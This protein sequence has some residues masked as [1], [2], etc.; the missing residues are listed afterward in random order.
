MTE[1]AVEV[2]LPKIGLTMQEGTIDE[3]LVPTGGVVAE[4][5]PLVRLA[6][7]KVDVDV[8]AEAGGLFHPVVPAGATVPAGALIGWLLAEGEELPGA[9]STG[10][11]TAPAD[12]VS[13]DSVPAGPN[14]VPAGGGVPSAA[15][16]LNGT[17][18]L[19][20]SGGRLLASPNARRVAAE[21]GVDLTAVRGTGPG[22]RI[23]SEDVEE[24]LLASAAQPPALL[25][26]DPVTPTSPLV[27]RLAKERG[28]DLADVRPTGA[29][30]RIRRADLDAATPA[31][32]SVPTPADAP[33]RS[34]ATPRQATASPQP[35]DVIP[36]TG[37]RGVIAR[38]MHASLQ[39]MAQL[40]HG[41]E[42]RMDAV[43]ALR[44]QLK[45]EWADTDLPVP[46]LGD[47]LMKAAALALRAHPLLNAS[48]LED[49]VHLYEDIHLGFAVAVPGGLLVP[50]I[51]NAAE[52]SLPE[53]ARRSRELADSARSG[54]ISPAL[55]EG[56]TFTVT[57]LGGYGVDFFTPVINPGNVAILGVGRL[58]DGVE[59]VDEQPRRTQVLTLSL[60]FDHRA[61]DGAPAA[62]YLRTV[63]E[64]LRAPLR[65]LV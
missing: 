59:W 25:S 34:T 17:A 2:L 3:W 12:S 58:R 24:Y 40:T 57:S 14:A 13:A 18:G 11:A 46:S 31:A 49:G 1:V 8:E 30:G 54:R 35:G 64:L 9:G 29:G 51:E 38:R 45:Q 37:M 5:D 63:G 32:T 36:L 33:A 61:V 10:G 56:A 43:V 23:V 50:V 15:P 21:A 28:I 65:L 16:S 52:L 27:R 55:L 4:G 47:F 42:V 53:V 60:T 26:A 41:Y 44:A 6:T 19:N 62:E 20:G 48:V 39:E 22:G 7:D